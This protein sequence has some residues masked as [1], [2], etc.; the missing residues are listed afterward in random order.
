[1][2]VPSRSA[3]ERLHA[4]PAAQPGDERRAEEHHQDV[5]HEHARPGLGELGEVEADAHEDDRDPQERAGEE[6]HPRL[7]RLR[8]ANG[9]THRGS[10]QEREAERPQHLDPRQ[11]GEEPGQQGE[12]KDQQGA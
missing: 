9:G 7:G 6:A 12:R 11:G 2:P 1:V 5:D 3:S 8:Q 10:E 4:E